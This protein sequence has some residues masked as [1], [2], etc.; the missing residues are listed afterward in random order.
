[1]IVRT[2]LNSPMVLPKV[3]VLAQLYSKF[4]TK[5]FYEYVADTKFNIGD[6]ADDHQFIKQCLLAFQKL[7]L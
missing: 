1:M 7:A 6:F 5:S 3:L 4:Y 2:L